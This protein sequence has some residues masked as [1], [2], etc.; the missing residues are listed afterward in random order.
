M[1]QTLCKVRGSWG[2]GGNIVTG[3][4]EEVLGLKKELRVIRVNSRR[5]AVKQPIEIQ[6]EGE[7]GCR[8]PQEQEDSCH[9]T[10]W[11]REGCLEYP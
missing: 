4:M 7:G 8:G 2:G 3:Q 1:G 6:S 5:Q 11:V 10:G 9:G